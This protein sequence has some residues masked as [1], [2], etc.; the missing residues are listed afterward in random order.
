[1]NTNFQENE[2]FELSP[3]KPINKVFK[4]ISPTCLE[5]ILPILILLEV[6]WGKAGFYQF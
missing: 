5:R 6:G 3:L 2:N 4:K 1:L